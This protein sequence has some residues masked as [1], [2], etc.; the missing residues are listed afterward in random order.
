L[1]LRGT[2]K[3][4]QNQIKPSKSAWISLVLFGRIR[5]F[6]WVTANPN[7]KNLF[8]SHTLAQ[9]SQPLSSPLSPRRW[10]AQDRGVRSDAE[11]SITRILFFRKKMQENSG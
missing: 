8:P 7:K 10:A 2:T 5:T 4:K 3:G 11:N 1:G 9:I 6:Q